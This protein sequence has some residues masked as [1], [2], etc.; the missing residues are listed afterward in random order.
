MIFS[1]FSQRNLVT[2]YSFIILLTVTLKTINITTIQIIEKPNS[3]QN[4][5]IHK[6]DKTQTRKDTLDN[7]QIN[8]T[9]RTNLY[10]IPSGNRPENTHDAVYWPSV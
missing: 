2:N 4:Q 10:C 9:K 5:I 1:L 3:T 7:I 8:N 6:P